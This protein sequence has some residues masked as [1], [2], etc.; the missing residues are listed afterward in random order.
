[1][2]GRPRGLSA[3]DPW[4]GNAVRVA[5]ASSEK[6]GQECLF[7]SLLHASSALGGLHPSSLNFILCREALLLQIRN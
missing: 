7:G 5:A 4:D 3:R 1:M 2:G 6:K